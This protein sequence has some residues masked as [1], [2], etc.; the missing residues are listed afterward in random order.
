MDSNPIHIKSN[1]QYCHREYVLNI[2]FKVNT[3]FSFEDI[4]SFSCLTIC[5]VKYT[6]IRRKHVFM[7]VPLFL[8]VE[9][10][11]CLPPCVCKTL[12]LGLQIIALFW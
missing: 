12:G 2:N 3:V 7:V 5:I 8:N 1:I 6:Y 4:Q 9:R 10:S 11:S